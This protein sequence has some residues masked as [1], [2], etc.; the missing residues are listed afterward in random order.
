MGSLSVSLVLSDQDILGSEPLWATQCFLNHCIVRDSQCGSTVHSS[1]TEVGGFNELCASKC[2]KHKIVEWIRISRILFC[3]HLLEGFWGCKK[4]GIFAKV[5]VCIK[6]FCGK[7]WM[8]FCPA[9]ASIGNP[10]PF[11]RF[12]HQRFESSQE[13]W[14]KKPGHWTNFNV[15]CVELPNFTWR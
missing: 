7:F 9:L 3:S 11:V 12:A 5:A 6:L 14:D 13:R 8:H 10:L 1:L 2:L 4:A 15:G